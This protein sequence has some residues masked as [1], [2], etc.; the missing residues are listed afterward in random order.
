MTWRRAARAPGCPRRSSCRSP[1][2]TR[3]EMS[4][5]TPMSCSIIHHGQALDPGHVRRAHHVSVSSGVHAAVG[6][7]SRRAAGDRGRAAGPAPRASA[8]PYGACPRSCAGCPAAREVDDLALHDGAVGSSPRAPPAVVEAA[9]EDAERRWDVAARSF[10]FVQARSLLPRTR[11]C[12]SGRCAR[13]PSLARWWGL[14]RGDVHGRRTRCG[15]AVA[16]RS[17]L[18]S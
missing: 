12:L 4:M 7:S 5:T 3:S 17:R 9:G 14:R 6:S 8:G 18:C 16:R 10:T 15:P 2:A 13:T 11:R 1:A